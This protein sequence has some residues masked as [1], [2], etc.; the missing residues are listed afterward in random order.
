MDSHPNYLR[1]FAPLR[2]IDQDEYM[3]ML[4]D[5]QSPAT[6]QSFLS[7]CLVVAT[8]DCGQRLC[9]VIRG[10][11]TCPCMDAIGFRT[12]GVTPRRRNLT[13]QTIVHSRLQH[14][15][16]REY[17]H[18]SPRRRLFLNLFET[19]GRPSVPRRRLCP[20]T[21]RACT[22][23]LSFHVT[24]TRKPGVPAREWGIPGWGRL[25]QN[26]NAGCQRAASCAASRRRR[27]RPFPV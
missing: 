27:R 25:L 14:P 20:P 26:A 15:G 6:P 3:P 24:I 11:E 8:I 12:T 9:R 18:N 17:H 22:C 21:A 16:F 10:Q 5:L 1:G 7:S 23:F 4:T 19:I 13:T 2:A